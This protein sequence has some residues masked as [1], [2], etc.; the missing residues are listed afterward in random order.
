[1]S[2]DSWS[3]AALRI[4]TGGCIESDAPAD[5][6]ASGLSYC[7]DRNKPCRVTPTCGGRPQPNP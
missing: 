5:E 6:G 1:M 4:M 3:G 2:T 7:A